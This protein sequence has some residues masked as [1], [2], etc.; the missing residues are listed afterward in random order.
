MPLDESD[1]GSDD[2][3]DVYKDNHTKWAILVCPKQKRWII[4][5][6]KP[7]CEIGEHDPDLSKPEETWFIAGFFDP[8]VEEILSAMRVIGGD[9]QETAERIDELLC[10]VCRTF[11]ESQAKLKEW[12]IKPPIDI[13][14]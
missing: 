9:G 10:G 1:A 8:N 5:L 4:S 12:E 2:L 6:V 13:P 14:E 7:N 3:P 11:V